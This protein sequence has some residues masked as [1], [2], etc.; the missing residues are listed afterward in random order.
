MECICGMWVCVCV[1]TVRP[2]YIHSSYF[3]LLLIFQKYS[4]FRSLFSLSLSLIVCLV[5]PK[6]R[7]GFCK[8]PPE[9]RNGMVY[10]PQDSKCYT[11]HTRGPCPKGKLFVMGKN[12]LAECKVDRH[13][14]MEIF[15]W[16]FIHETAPSLPKWPDGNIVIVVFFRRK[17]QTTLFSI[18]NCYFEN[19]ND[20]IV[21]WMDISIFRSIMELS[22][23]A[24]QKKSK[25]DWFHNWRETPIFFLGKVSV[26]VLTF[27]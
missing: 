3:V 8:T 16:N 9:C 5:R 6:K 14:R 21:S 17:L 7:K 26:F 22:S 10:W 18:R 4:F 27:I 20:G 15:L 1:C 2:L 19:D 24:R 25:I 13:S 11:L 23:L 12:R